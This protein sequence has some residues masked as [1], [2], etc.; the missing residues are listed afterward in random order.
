MVA[1]ATVDAT[2]TPAVEQVQEALGVTLG[3]TLS[4]ETA[5]RL[6][7]QSGAVAEAQTQAAITRAR[8]GQPVWPEAAG[9]AGVAGDGSAAG[10]R[11][12]H[13]GRG[14]GWHPGASGGGLA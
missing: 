4:D 8:Q 12:P 2:F 3:V 10:G 5:R 6:A 13:L 7:E 14:G 11:P 1:R 9:P